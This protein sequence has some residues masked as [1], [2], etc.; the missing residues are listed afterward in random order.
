MLSLPT[1]QRQHPNQ[2]RNSASTLAPSSLCVAE[3][4]QHWEIRSRMILDYDSNAQHTLEKDSC[5]LALHSL[6]PAMESRFPKPSLGTLDAI[7]VELRLCDLIAGSDISPYV[8][9][10]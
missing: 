9:E 2:V 1:A 4:P 10:N 7:V 5:H 6:A 3:L 8:W